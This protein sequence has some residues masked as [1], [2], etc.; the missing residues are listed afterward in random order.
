ML[1]ALELTGRAHSHVLDGAA[2]G[3]ALH[4]AVIPAWLALRA[5]ARAAGIELEIV[6]GFR[7][8]ARQVAIWNAKFRGERRLFDRSGREVERA[9][10][11]DH[12]LIEVI[13][14]WSALPGAS[15]HHWGT[16]IDVIDRAAVAEDYRPQL[17]PREFAAGG[18]FARLDGWLA[19]HMERFGFFRPYTTD[20]GGVSPEPWHL[21][22]APEA[23]PAQRALTF[24]VLRDAVAGSGMDGREPVLAR[25]PQL[26]ERFVLATD[27]AP[28]AAR[29]RNPTPS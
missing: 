27:P 13:L 26:Y 28:G 1:N 3:H 14:A 16:D 29:L 4:T 6:S 18:P 8:F 20:R 15:R 24:E 7:D 17:L 19:G 11:D 21:S 22:Y 12:A 10:L 25:L 23:V 2:P 9:G 5:Q